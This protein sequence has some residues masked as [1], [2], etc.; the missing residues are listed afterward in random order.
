MQICPF[1]PS[2]GEGQNVTAGAAAAVA[3]RSSDLTVVVFNK[4][5]TEIAHVRLGTGDATAAD[6]IVPPG[7]FVCLAKGDGIVRLSYFS[8]GTPDLFITTGNGW[9]SN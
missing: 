2:A 4:D 1:M 5:A 8:A 7:K 3:L 9:L 6:M